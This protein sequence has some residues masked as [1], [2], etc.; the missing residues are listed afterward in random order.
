MCYFSIDDLEGCEGI[1]VDA[2]KLRSAAIAERYKNGGEISAE[3]SD[4]IKENRKLV[5]IAVEQLNS[6]LSKNNGDVPFLAR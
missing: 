4:Y 2:L 5:K 3:D 1:D 6:K